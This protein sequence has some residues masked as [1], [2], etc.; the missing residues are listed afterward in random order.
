M[1]LV[2]VAIGSVRWRSGSGLV[3]GS[4][5]CRQIL[6][7]GVAFA[8]GVWAKTPVG[9]TDPWEAGATR[10]VLPRPFQGDLH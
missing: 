2:D 9:I 10:G 8:T 3:A 5:A 7:G 6:Q 4:V 1:I